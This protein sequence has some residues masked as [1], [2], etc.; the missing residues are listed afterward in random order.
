M[1]TTVTDPPLRTH[2]DVVAAGRDA[3]DQPLPTLRDRLCPPMPDD[4]VWGWIGPLLVTAVA[5]F[6][7]LFELGRPAKFVFDET[8]YPKDAFGLLNFGVEHQFVDKVN[9]RIL[10]GDLDVFQGPAFVVHPPAGKWLIAIGEWAFGM[11]PF[12]WRVAVAVMGTLSVLVMARVVRRMTRS[13]L[14]GCVAGFL[15]AID[16]LHLVESRIALLDLPAMAWLLLAFAALV[17]DR[18]WARRRLADAAEPA[19]RLSRGSWGPALLWRPWRL[20]AGVCFGLAAATKWNAAVVIAGFGLLTWVWD[21][22]A[23]RAIGS[24]FATVANAGRLVLDAV[25]AF[26]TVV[27]SAVAVYLLSWTGWFASS[28]GYNRTWA[29]DH[30]ASGLARLVPDALRSLWHYHAEMLHFHTTLHEEHQYASSPAGWLVIARPVSFDWADKLGPE[31]GCAGDNCVQEIL[32]IGTPVLW[33]GAVLALAAC[34]FWWIGMRD[35]RFGVP[36]VG[37]ATTWLPWFAYTDRPIFYFYAVVILPWLVI[38]VTLVLGKII[39]PADAPSTRRMWGAAA[40][41]SFV[42]LVLL[43]FAYLHPILTDQVIPYEEWL[44]RMWFRSWI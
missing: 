31:H 6:L 44:R 23:R 20:V 32:A 16:G 28:D 18:D 29:E 40:A 34:G 13:T 14:L 22:G 8:Y 36:L 19:G 37:V 15:L 41:G 30:P 10:A 17:V 21:I 42:L 1:R 7:R 12:G 3:D 27:G 39:G 25:V 33:W 43:N 38:A 24:T 2:D 11:N 4:G 9:E 35:W 26:V 5:G